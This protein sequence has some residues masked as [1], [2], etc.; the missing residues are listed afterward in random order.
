MT[1]TRQERGFAY[2]SGMIKYLLFDLY[3]FTCQHACVQKLRRAE[4]DHFAPPA[5]PATC[6]RTIAKIFVSSIMQRITT[7]TDPSGKGLPVTVGLRKILP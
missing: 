5:S 2:I 1:Q 4:R 7:L 6:T 3:A